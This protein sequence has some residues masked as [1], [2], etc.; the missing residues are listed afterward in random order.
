M[1]PK[2]KSLRKKAQVFLCLVD[3]LLGED[4]FQKL[5]KFGE[6]PTNEMMNWSYETTKDMNIDI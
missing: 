5:V 1:Y 4:I 3:V 6:K 2:D